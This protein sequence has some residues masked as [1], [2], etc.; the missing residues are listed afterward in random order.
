MPPTNDDWESRNFGIFILGAGFSAPAGLPLADE[1]WS[2]ILT[3]ARTF[4]GRAQ[5]FWD[6]LDYYIDF[7]RRADGKALNREQVNFEEFLGFLDVEHYLGLR[8]SDTW[9]EDGNETQ[10]VI[11]TQIGKILSRRMPEPGKIPAVY[12][13]FAEKL[14]PSDLILT[15]NY[16]LLLE[17]SLESVG[18]PYRLFPRRYESVRK[19]ISTVDYSQ[20]EVVV[21]KL[22]KDI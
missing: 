16:D 18:K 14:Q 17:R 12:L 20:D 5:Q 1:L 7:R 8:G 11:K 9:S 4:Q 15:F 22:A 6:D 3:H 10:V 13:R 21:L 2:D 19:H